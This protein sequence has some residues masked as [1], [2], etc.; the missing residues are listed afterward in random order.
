MAGLPVTYDEKVAKE[1]RIR[2]Q[3]KLIWK[4]VSKRLLH[5]KQIA[6]AYA[7]TIL[8]GCATAFA[9]LK[10]ACKRYHCIIGSDEGKKD[11]EIR[12]RNGTYSGLS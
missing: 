2:A 1:R 11:S 6:A 12:I 7:C 9:A 5:T 10:D 3:R 8:D 4:H